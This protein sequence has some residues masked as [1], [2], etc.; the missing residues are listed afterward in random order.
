MSHHGYDVK[1]EQHTTHHGGTKLTGV[2][3]R[4]N[5]RTGSDDDAR[6]RSSEVNRDNP[7]S[8]EKVQE[9]LFGEQL[10]ELAQRISHLEELAAPGARELK[11]EGIRITAD[12]EERG[13]RT[14]SHPNGNLEDLQRLLLKAERKRI[15][16]LEERLKNSVLE[17]SAVADVLPDA[18][19]QRR[20]PR[21][22]VFGR[23][24]ADGIREAPAF[25]ADALSPVIGP[26]IRN[27]IV[28]ALQDIMQS[29]NLMLD[30]IVSWRGLAWRWEALRTGKSFGE[31]VL[32][33]TLKYR[34]ERVFLFFK[35]D[36]I[37]LGDVHH[38]DV[39]PFEL[40]KEDLVTSMFSAIKTAVQK[41]AQDELGVCEHASMKEIKTDDGFTLLI[42]QGPKAV[43][44]AAVRGLPSQSL[45]TKLQDTLDSIHLELRQA[46]ESFR[47]DKNAFEA[48]RPYLESCL[49]QEE[50]ESISKTGSARG[51]L[52][53]ALIVLLILVGGTLT[54][55]GITSYFEQQRWADFQD[56]AREKP[57]IHITSVDKASGK[58]GKAVVYGLRDP[59]SDDPQEIARE[60]G[61]PHEAIDYQFEPYLSLAP[62]LIERRAR[63]ATGEIH[64]AKSQRAR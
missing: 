17:A 62:E 23:V 8:L 51:G 52:S 3:L 34:V 13:T 33:H 61:L 20:K 54:W 53:P 40:G 19:R 2:S 25:F 26:A 4:A 15:D 56:K 55:W 22:P 39:Q 57:G 29:L 12:F 49:L 63:A 11:P 59:L 35:E 46:L 37:H 41:F 24:L 7:D 43:L 60:V 27:A 36:G 50:S 18:I 47:G 45:R 30:H 21:E 32:S 14:A 16:K 42:E 9:L 38:P 28:T 5:N 31:V 44:A 48:A 10:R 58:N 64:G 1:E 6:N